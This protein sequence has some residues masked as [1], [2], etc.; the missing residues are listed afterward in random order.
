[1]CTIMN[2]G[3]N[4]TRYDGF[5]FWFL[6]VGIADMLLWLVCVIVSESL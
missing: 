2:S 5:I 3:P 4:R 6:G 1:M